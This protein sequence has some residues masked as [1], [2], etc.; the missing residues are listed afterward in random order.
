M[1]ISYHVF[2]IGCPQPTT[3]E[4]TKFGCCNDGLSPALGKNGEGC[5]PSQCNETLFG[6]CP[7]GVTTAEGNEFEGCPV[8]TTLPFD[9][10]KTQ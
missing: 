4:E 3:C 5:P 1:L 10:K 6:C 8:E 7:D 9:C 2:L